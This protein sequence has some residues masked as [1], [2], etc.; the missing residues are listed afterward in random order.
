MCCRRR[1]SQRSASSE[2]APA[3]RR[4]STCCAPASPRS[5]GTERR[6]ATAGRRADGAVRR[7]RAAREYIDPAETR[8]RRRRRRRGGGCGPRPRPRGRR[9]AR[10]DGTAG[11]RPRG[12]QGATRRRAAVA[13]DSVTFTR[14]AGDE[15]GEDEGGL[16][17]E[18]LRPLLGLDARAR[19]RAH[20][21]ASAL[22]TRRGRARRADAARR[23]AAPAALRR[24]HD[25]RQDGPRGGA[26]RRR[27]GEGLLRFL[28]DG[29]MPSSNVYGGSS[30]LDARDGS[31]SSAAA[32]LELLRDYDPT[33]AAACAQLLRDD[34]PPLDESLT[35][36]DFRFC[37]HDEGCTCECC[38][39]AVTRE[40]VAQAV[41]HRCNWKL[42]GCRRAACK[43]VR[44][45]FTSL[46]DLSTQLAAFTNDERMRLL[47]G[48]P[49]LS[50]AALVGCFDWS[51]QEPRRRRR[52]LRQRGA[53]RA[54]KDSGDA[55][56]PPQ[57]RH[58]LRRGAPPPAPPLD[59]RAPRAAGGRPR[60]RQPADARRGGG[61]AGGGGGGGA[62]ADRAHLRA[63]ARLP[64]YASREALRERLCFA[65][66][67]ST[68]S[69]DIQ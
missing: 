33:E 34:A 68:G 28:G 43:A 57:R 53:A 10:S 11:R 50:S 64:P 16:T 12:R 40:N 13:L 32:A 69:F 55:P 61:G 42:V 8:T 29:Y 1:R 19:G 4:R 26:S 41:V 30:A 52:P 66:D 17:T 6:A 54:R 48:E 3:R 39:T 2:R 62:A 35:M 15:E 24:R 20:R 5:R 14:D 67:H 25:A 45:G 51:K 36:G 63:R 58:R 21:R 37:G 56:L 65:L 49:R 46:I 7:A 59:D 27:P 23:R 22:R 31:A 9:R 38:A 44:E 18:M 47:Q 60:P